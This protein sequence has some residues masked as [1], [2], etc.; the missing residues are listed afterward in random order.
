MDLEAIKNVKASF[1]VI[2][3]ELGK[4]PTPQ[5]VKALVKQH[6]GVEITDDEAKT[7]VADPIRKLDP[8]N[9]SY[10]YLHSLAFVLRPYLRVGWGSQTHTSSPLYAFGMGP[11]SEPITGLIHNTQLFGV[12]KTALGE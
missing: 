3:E 10:P 4:K 11:G 12:M 9:Y 2:Q 6:I 1:E 8:A 5:Q 7:V